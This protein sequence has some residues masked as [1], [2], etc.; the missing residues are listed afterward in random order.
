MHSA[1]VLVFGTTAILSG[2]N[3]W[4]N[5]TGIDLY[6]GSFQNETGSDGIGDTPYLIGPGNRD[7]YPLMD[8]YYDYDVA[9]T[10]LVPSKTVAPN[11]TIFEVNM[12]IE[13]QGWSS[14]TTNLTLSA[15]FLYL[16]QTQT[17]M[18]QANTVQGWNFSTPGPT[19]TAVF[20]DT[21]SLSLISNDS[22]HH[23]FYIDYN[24]NAFPDTGE[25]QSA[26]FI[27]T[28]LTF[29]CTVDH[30]GTFTYYCAYNQNTM[31]GSLIVNPQP[32]IMRSWSQNIS[33]ESKTNVSI[34]FPCSFAGL[35]FGS[36]QMKAYA[37]PAPNEIDTADNSLTD[38]LVIVTI[39]G[40]V[41]GD[42]KVDVKDVYAVG[43]AFGTSLE[44]PNPPGYSYNPNCDID[45]DE[46][47]N[48]KD[49]YQVCKHYGEF[50]P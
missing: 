37:K 44:G 42:N 31:F 7:N 1:V 10:N 24:G 15:T 21:L 11:D 46:K 50:E 32:E 13:N 22:L 12:T 20:G 9:V 29:L 45:C 8:P 30:I 17:I 3:Y 35:P 18:L 48:M 14:T 41:N 25:P 28:N 43:R 16:S 6:R 38:G 40:D 34:L 33:I 36:Y 23:K 39:L 47:I 49:Y 19:I 2:G 5:Y 27:N 26:D 4:G